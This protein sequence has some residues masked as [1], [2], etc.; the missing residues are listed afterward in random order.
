MGI[1]HHQMG[2]HGYL[3]NFGHSF[4]DGKTE[5]NIGDETAVHHIEMDDVGR[6]VEHSDI[7]AEIGEIGR[8]YRRCYL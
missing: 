6:T 1:N 5:G 4:H 3:G 2:I 8:Q 7:P